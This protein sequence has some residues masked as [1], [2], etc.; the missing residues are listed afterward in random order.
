MSE[1]RGGWGGA[2]PEETGGGVDAR[3]YEGATV[4]SGLDPDEGV[5]DVFPPRRF[6]C[7]A[8]KITR[9]ISYLLNVG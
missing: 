2:L 3:L 5:E 9:K 1:R 8:H 6:S 7:Q 4:C